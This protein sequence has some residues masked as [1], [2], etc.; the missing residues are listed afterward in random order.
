MNTYLTIID[1]FITLL[2]LS[3]VFTVLP[4]CF[5]GAC[6]EAPNYARKIRIAWQNRRSVRRRVMSQALLVK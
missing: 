5:I 6:M 1:Q 3:L 4:I 2:M